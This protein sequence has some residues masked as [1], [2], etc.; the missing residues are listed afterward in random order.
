MNKALFCAIHCSSFPESD[1][2]NSSNPLKYMLQ[3]YFTVED[4]GGTEALTICPDTSNKW[5]SQHPM[6]SS[7]LV[8]VSIEQDYF[9]VDSAAHTD[10]RPSDATPRSCL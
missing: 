3:C 8:L 7:P 10:L 9:S 1:S 2:F 4:I 5:Q 6:C